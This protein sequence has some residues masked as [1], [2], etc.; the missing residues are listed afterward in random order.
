M[1][2]LNCSRFAC[3]YT[4]DNNI[5]LIFHRTHK[6]LVGCQ[7]VSPAMYF[8]VTERTVSGDLIVSV[9]ESTS[10]WPCLSPEQHQYVKCSCA[11]FIFIVHVPFSAQLCEWVRLAN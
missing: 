5:F 11:Y 6:C 7:F 8:S 1:E 10:R 9:L 2:N 3:P 4:T